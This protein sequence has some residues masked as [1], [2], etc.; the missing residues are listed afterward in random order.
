MSTRP[1]VVVDPDSEL[2]RLQAQRVRGQVRKRAVLERFCLKF[3]DLR[4]DEQL[5]A[6]ASDLRGA[7]RKESD[8][9]RS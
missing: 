8:E 6:L 7:S 9:P 5:D 3:P 4:I 1:V 2:E